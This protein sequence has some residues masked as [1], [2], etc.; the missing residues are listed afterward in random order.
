ML[1]A[2]QRDDQA[3]T[4]LMRLFRGAGVSGLAGMRM[5]RTVGQGVLLRPLLNFGRAEL[6]Q[7]VSAS[8]LPWIED[9]SNQRDDYL[10]NWVR[11]ALAPVLEQRWR[12]WSTKLLESAVS[13]EESAQLNAELALIDAGG[14]FTNPLPLNAETPQSP[15]RA[16]N[17][18]YHWLRSLQVV[19]ASRAQLHDLAVQIE[20]G[21]TGSWIIGDHKVHL[22]QQ[23]LWL[24]RAHLPSQDSRE[25]RLAEGIETLS[26]GR[27]ELRSAERGLPAGLNVRVRPRREGDLIQLPVGSQSIKKYM[28]A[29]KIPPWLREAWPLVEY[30]GE[31]IAVVGLWYCE[32]WLEPGGL[33]LNWQTG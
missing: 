28:N 20:Q 17:L 5:S 30:Q 7:V 27:L 11:N 18:V 26:F 21:T 33:S 29:Q 22:Y 9:P 31:I 2:H 3:E 16:R 23:Q 4:V 24:S 25:L 10:R 19:P 15:I 1:L 12:G 6:E 32:R 14:L 8:K 13:F